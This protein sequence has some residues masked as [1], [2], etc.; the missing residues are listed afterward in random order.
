MLRQF[1]K[2]TPVSQ[3]A[4]ESIPALLAAEILS[5]EDAVL[6]ERLQFKRAQDTAAVLEKDAGIAARL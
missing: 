2:R 4:S 6:A 5:I 3:P 1:W